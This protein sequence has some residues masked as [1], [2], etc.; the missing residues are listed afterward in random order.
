MKIQIHV[1]MGD[2]TKVSNEERREEGLG[3]LLNHTSVGGVHI[4]YGMCDQHTQNR[5]EEEMHSDFFFNKGK[6]VLLDGENKLDK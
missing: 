5:N 2:P 4:R 6:L 3:P 1:A